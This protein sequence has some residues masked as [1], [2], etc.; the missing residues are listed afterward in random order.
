MKEVLI[1]GRGK[2][3][4]LHTICYDK[5]GYNIKKYY[6]DINE[7]IKEIIEKNK[8]DKENL[9]IDITTPK[10]V[11]F[12]IID[13]C[14]KLGLYDIIVEKP[15]VVEEDFFIKHPKLNIVMVQNYIYSNVTNYLKKLLSTN[16]LKVKFMSTNFSKNRILESIKRRGMSSKITENIEVEIPHQIYLCDYILGEKSKLVFLEQKDMISENIRLKKYGH[17]YSIMK[18][19]NSIITHTS[20]LTSNILQKQLCIYCDKDYSII[21]NYPIYDANFKCLNDGKVEIFKDKIKIHEVNIVDDMMMYCLKEYYEIFNKK[22]YSNIYKERILS[23]SRSMI[24]FKTF[25][26]KQEII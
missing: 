16:N 1:V 7:G 22:E 25:S 4:K 18:N 10:E 21:V 5:S 14:E 15:F 2:A 9:I 23:F 13:Q 6:A 19:T 12:E 11:F 26:D 3:S 17:S 8:L 20:D 24:E